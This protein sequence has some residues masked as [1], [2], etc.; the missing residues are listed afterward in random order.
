VSADASKSYRSLPIAVVGMALRAPGAGT[1]EQFWHNIERGIDCL[2]RTPVDKLREA[3]VP[4]RLREDP[5]YVAAK[6]TRS[7]SWRRRSPPRASDAGGSGRPTRSTR[8]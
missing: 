7:T 6:P 2:T 5:R 4:E 3:G 1:P 8:S